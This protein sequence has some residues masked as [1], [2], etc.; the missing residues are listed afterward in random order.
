MR[1]TPTCWTLFSLLTTSLGALRKHSVVVYRLH[2]IAHVLAAL[3]ACLQRSTACTSFS[4]TT[5]GSTIWPTP[6][7]GRSVSIPHCQ[8]PNTRD[9]QFLGSR[10]HRHVPSE[11]YDGV[12]MIDD[13]RPS[14]RAISDLVFKGPSGLAN[15][16]NA[17]T[18]LAFF[19]NTVFLPSPPVSC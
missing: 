12:Y 13:H 6:N 17:T 18:M 7:G 5:A 14:A 2:L 10:L 8:P 15:K 11:Y 9:A 3:I 19:S 4:A 16:R 1:P